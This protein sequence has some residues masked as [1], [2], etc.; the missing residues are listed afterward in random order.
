MCAYNSI[1]GEPGCA[2]EF[3]LQDQLRG[4]WDFKGYV[5]SDCG[6]VVD[7]YQRPPLQTHAA[8]GFSDQPAAWHGQ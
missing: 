2:N 4:K 1:N 7:I 6:A 5:V 3:L 8:A